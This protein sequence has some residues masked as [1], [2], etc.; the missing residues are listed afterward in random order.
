MNKYLIDSFKAI[1]TTVTDERISAAF[2]EYK[3]KKEGRG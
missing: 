2:A 1:G 3:E